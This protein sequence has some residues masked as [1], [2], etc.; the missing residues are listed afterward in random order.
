MKKIFT[1]IISLLIISASAEKINWNKVIIGKWLCKNVLLWEEHSVEDLIFEFRKN[2]KMIIYYKNNSIH[3]TGIFK[4]KNNII[5][6]GTKESQSY[7]LFDYNNNEIILNI[8]KG[9]NEVFTC[10]EDGNFPSSF[11]FIKIK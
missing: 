7:E 4:I 6:F 2:N 11:T 1:V 8:I 3:G 5:Q 10:E 9:K